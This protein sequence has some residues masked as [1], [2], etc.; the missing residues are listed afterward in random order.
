MEIIDIGEAD[1]GCEERLGD[2]PLM[3]S[4][5]VKTDEGDIIY[6]EIPDEFAKELGLIKGLQFSKEEFDEILKGKIPS[7][8]DDINNRHDYQTDIGL[9]CMAGSEYKEYMLRSKGI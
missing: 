6:K 9:V 3:C 5:K 1:Y 2:A 4:L 7:N 8:W